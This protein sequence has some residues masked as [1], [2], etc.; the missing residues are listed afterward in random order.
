MLREHNHYFKDV[1]GL[2]SIDVYRVLQLFN[3]TDPCI[4]HAVKKLLVA[5][6]RGAGK[7]IGRDIKEAIDS[8]ERWQE[9]REEEAPPQ[10]HIHVSAFDPEAFKK[11]VRELGRRV[12][13]AFKRKPDD[14]DTVVTELRTAG[15][16]EKVKPKLYDGEQEHL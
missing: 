15:V 6:G 5:G 7:D 4:Q 10:I 11:A 14:L 16:P 8:L 3:V 9:M 2:D 12:A 1:S 13:S